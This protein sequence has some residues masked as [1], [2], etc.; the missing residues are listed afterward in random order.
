MLSFIITFVNKLIIYIRIKN[1]GKK[2]LTLG[3]LIGMVGLT[4]GQ[5]WVHSGGSLY[6]FIEVSS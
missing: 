4:Y 2:I 6:N 3:F 1:M 5:G